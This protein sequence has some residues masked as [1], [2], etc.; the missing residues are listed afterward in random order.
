MV[1]LFCAV[2]PARSTAQIHMVLKAW[3][4]DLH[5]PAGPNRIQPADKAQ[6]FS[7]TPYI[8][9]RAEIFSTIISSDISCHKNTRPFFINRDF[10]IGIRFIITEGNIVLR[11]QFFNQIAFQNKSF[12]LCC[13]HGDIQIRCMTDHGCHFRRAV[14]IFPHIGTNSVF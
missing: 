8:S 11:V 10:H 6:R 7:Q 13:R 3:T 14:L 1:L 5:T 12:H 2:I 4:A 9:K